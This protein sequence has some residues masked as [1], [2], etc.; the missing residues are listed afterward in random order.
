MFMQELSPGCKP[1]E[2]KGIELGLSGKDCSHHGVKRISKTVS[3][4][5]IL[6]G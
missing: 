2:A 1:E 5:P 3:Q 4:A 6:Q